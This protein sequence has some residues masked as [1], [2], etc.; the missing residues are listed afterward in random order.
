[1]ISITLARFYIRIEI[2]RSAKN[3]SD[4]IEEHHKYM[5]KSNYEAKGIAKH[6]ANMVK[7]VV[8]SSVPKLTLLI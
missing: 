5:I 7:A 3:S 1:M 8:T 4:F 2:V 6:R